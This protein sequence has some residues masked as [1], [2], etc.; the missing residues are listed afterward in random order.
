MALQQINQGLDIPIDGDP[1]QEIEPARPVNRIAIMANDYVGM[2]PT[3]KVKPGDFVK[4]GQILFEDKKMPGVFFTAPGAGT[5]KAVNRGERRALQSVVIDLSESEKKN[6]WN[7]DEVQI[8]ESYQPKANPNEFSRDEVQALLIESGLWTALRARPFGRV[9]KPETVPHALFINLMDTNPHAPSV[10]VVM[11]GS[12]TAFAAGV[13]ILSKLPE[14]I[15]YVC[16]APQTD[17]PILRA[18]NVKIEEF[19]GPHPAGT[20]GVHMHYL[21]PVTREKINWYVNYQDVIAV[22]KLFSTG[23]LDVE[24]VLSLAGPTVKNPRL[25]RTRLGACIDEL[26]QDE[27]EDTENRVIS[28]SVLNGVNAQ[29]GIFGYLGRYHHQISA[30]EEGHKR[31]FLGWLTLGSDKF[32][33]IRTFLSG[34][35]KPKK[36]KFSTTTNGSDRAM[37]PIGMY[38]RVM[39][40]DIM[41][42]FLLRSMVMGDIEKAEKLGILELEEEDLA[43]CTFV[44][45][46]KTEYGPILRKNLDTIEKEG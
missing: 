31:E 41:P 25:L 42:T 9:A 22:G 37:V 4:R 6:K 21:A 1:K 20:V 35:Q 19:T 28:G 30:L 3:M 27:L 40:M 43:L 38:E 23:K 36:F 18:E 26:C 34:W 7:E 12:E 24:R 14:S 5:V 8:F 11:R 15:A 32:S 17:M 45:P 44:C 16:K 46:G 13:A 39:P 10:D 33:I 2:K 29:G